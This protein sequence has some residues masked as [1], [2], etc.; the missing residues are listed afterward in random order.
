MSSIALLNTWIQKHHLKPPTFEYAMENCQFA[1]TIT[2]EFEGSLLQGESEF[3]STKKAAKDQACANFMKSYPEL[4]VFKADYDEKNIKTDYI[5]AL[6]IYCQKTR[7]PM[8]EYV[9]TPVG[10]GFTCRVTV[11]SD[12]GIIQEDLFPAAFSSKKLAKAAAA[13]RALDRISGSTEGE[14]EVDTFPS[15]LK[16]DTDWGDERETRPPGNLLGAIGDP[17]SPP[18]GFLSRAKK[19]SNVGLGSSEAQSSTAS[20]MKPSTQPFSPMST[21]TT[22]S[23]TSSAVE[24]VVTSFAVEGE[25]TRKLRDWCFS[26][27]IAEPKFVHSHDSGFLK[28]SL[29]IKL[30]GC[31]YSFSSD[32]KAAS[33]E[34]ADSIASRKALAFV[35]NRIR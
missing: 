24:S 8:P 18:F 4:M 16:D 9:M 27:G 12:S 2:V 29:K 7:R 26:N 30:G 34:E 25:S 20:M 31:V 22:T 13:A 23:L 10:M 15:A 5:S 14:A 33:L 11:D 17:V 32:S 21:L 19:H 3:F 1:C 28:S 35:E 6:N